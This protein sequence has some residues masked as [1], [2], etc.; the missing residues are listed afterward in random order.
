MAINT[1]RKEMP[2]GDGNPT[3]GNA[4]SDLDFPTTQRPGK[5][6]ETRRAAFALKGHALHRTHLAYGQLTYWAKRWG[7]V[8]YLPNLH[9]AALLLA[10]IGER[11]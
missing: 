7:L 10:Q 9:D 11:L 5:A 4:I 3:A 8:R 6:F 1:T 2:T